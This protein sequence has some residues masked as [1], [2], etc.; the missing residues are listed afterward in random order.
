MTSLRIESG[1]LIFRFTTCVCVLLWFISLAACTQDPSACQSSAQCFAQERCQQG[2]CVVTGSPDEDLGAPV[3]DMN[4]QDMSQQDMA[5]LPPTLCEQLGCER[6][7]L[8]CDVTTESCVEC[9][10]NAECGPNQYCEE[11]MCKVLPPG[12]P[13]TFSPESDELSLNHIFTQE[14][15]PAQYAHFYMTGAF[16][17]RAEERLTTWGQGSIQLV[18]SMVQ[19]Q[20][21]IMVCESFERTSPEERCAQAVTLENFPEGTQNFDVNVFQIS[22][23]LSSF[24][25]PERELEEGTE[26]PQVIILLQDECNTADPT[27]ARLD[28]EL[29]RDASVDLV[30]YG[31]QSTVEVRRSYQLQL[32]Q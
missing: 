23:A 25:L 9:R 24:S 21:Q 1:S 32:E 6:E 18:D 10:E 15:G 20:W 7:G 30:A 8:I 29:I 13:I 26:V 22:D 3:Q 19:C 16:S 17:V 27:Q 11:K 4:R 14:R 2:L 31:A 28:P 5:S 12:P